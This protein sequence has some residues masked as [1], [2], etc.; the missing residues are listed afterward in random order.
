[1]LRLRPCVAL[2]GTLLLQS[3][4]TLVPTQELAFQPVLR[5]QHSQEQAA[6]YYQIGKYHQERG[7]FPRALAA[8]T[9]SIFLDSKQ[10]DARSAIASIDSQQGRLLEAEAAFLGLMID[11]PMVAQPVNNLGYVYYL[12][13]KYA[14]AV[15]IFQRAL[16]LDR[17]NKKTRNNLDMARTALAL[18][19]APATVKLATTS[20]ALQ[21]QPASSSLLAVPAGP[22]AGS[23]RMEVVQLAPAEY[24]LKLR[25]GAMQSAPGVA[26]ALGV[27]TET[28]R[29]C[30][31]EI[32]NGNGVTGMARQVRQALVKQGIAVSRLT[33]V[34]PYRQTETEIQYLA[35]YEREAAALK[36]A[37]LSKSVLVAVSQLSGM[38]DVRLVLGKDTVT[39]SAFSGVQ[40]N[41]ASLALN[42]Q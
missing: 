34:R 10:L 4:S 2:L 41:V 28:A 15:S 17:S 23:G 1:V 42:A 21:G 18:L 33:N 14:D 25:G 36:K 9:Q 24:E 6:T 11:F 16:A 20:L 19:N 32:A 37:L 12:E 39:R 3:C 7:E 5:I 22:L 29:A 30:N 26:V 27:A 8:Y 38:A 35:G 13:G 31:V 40:D